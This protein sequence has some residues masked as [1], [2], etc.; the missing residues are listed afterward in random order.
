MKY[1]Q[2]KVCWKVVLGWILVR[3]GRSKNWG[4]EGESHGGYW[5][6]VREVANRWHFGDVMTDTAPLVDI[7]C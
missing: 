2:R 1:S 6:G 3:K 4:K 5:M 7:G